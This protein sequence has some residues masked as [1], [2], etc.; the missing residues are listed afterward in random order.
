MTEELC[1]ASPVRSRALA[2]VLQAGTDDLLDLSDHNDAG[3]HLRHLLAGEGLRRVPHGAVGRDHGL[4]SHVV[5]VVASF[6]T[7]RAG[8]QK[9]IYHLSCKLETKH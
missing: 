7:L 2:Q 9:G 4:R 1:P 3:Q 6:H 5:Y 8:R